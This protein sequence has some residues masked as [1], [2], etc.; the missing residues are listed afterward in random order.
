MGFRINKT[1]NINFDTPQEMYS[2]YKNRKI[3]GPLDYQSDM[4]DLYMEE[5][6]EK[7]DVALELPTG[8]GKTLIGL[9]IGEFRRTLCVRRPM[10]S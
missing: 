5:A 1:D 2:D 4:I 8:S 6:F 3:N 10:S 9:L 7:P